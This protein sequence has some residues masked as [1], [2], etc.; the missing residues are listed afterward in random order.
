MSDMA[1][2]KIDEKDGCHF[3]YEISF[4]NVKYDENLATL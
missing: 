1:Y 3:N 4:K 2:K